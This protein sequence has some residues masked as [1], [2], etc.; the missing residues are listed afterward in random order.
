MILRYPVSYFLT[1][2]DGISQQTVV[3]GN[4]KVSTFTAGTGLLSFST[5]PPISVQY[6]VVA[7]GGSGSSSHSCG[8]GGAGGLLTGAFGNLQLN[9]TYTL[10]IGGGGAATNNSVNQPGIQGSPSSFHIISTVGG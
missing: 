9:T 2:S 1:T 5:S 6:L 3:V 7:G 8:G 4:L 10:T